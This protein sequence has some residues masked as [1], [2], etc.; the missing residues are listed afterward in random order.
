MV[1][2]RL[3]LRTHLDNRLRLVGRNRSGVRIQREA[4]YESDS[5]G[6][7]QN[8]GNSKFTVRHTM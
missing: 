1:G 7:E 4:G 5:R 2:I 6:Y 3:Q 8:G